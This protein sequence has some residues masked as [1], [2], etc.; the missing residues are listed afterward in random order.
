MKKI[1]VLLVATLFLSGCT[2]Q[3]NY[4]ME[5]KNDKS[6]DFSVI[7]AFDDELIDMM[8]SSEN[9]DTTGTTD[10]QGTTDTTGTVNNE[11]TDEE[12]WAFI[13]SLAEDSSELKDAGYTTE[14]YEKDGYKGIIATKTIDN[15]DDVTGENPNFYLANYD[16]VGDAVMFKKNGDTYSA[17]LILSAPDQAQINMNLNGTGIVSTFTVTLPNKPISHNAINVSEDGKTLTWN[18]TGN[19]SENIEF[20]FSFGNNM[21]LYI[22]LGIAGL[23][24]LLLIIFLVIKR[25]KNKKNK[26]GLTN[27]SNPNN[28][29]M[30][31][32]QTTSIGV[33]PNARNISQNLNINS[34]NANTVSAS[35]SLE[36]PSEVVPPMSTPV[37]NQNI[38]NVP[39]VTSQNINSVPPVINKNNTVEA[40]PLNFDS[41]QNNN[42]NNR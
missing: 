6:F 13:D 2:M 11:Y 23:I 31:A 3:G 19:G 36:T 14:R 9:S 35:K 25:R 15:I 38:N 20:E 24:V 12:R 33:Q 32:N 29:S 37:T 16:T 8:L 5:I 7:M 27:P 22:G 34:V 39:P 40:K 18:L 17:N 41:N 1:I 28:I 10:N 42:F 21:L 4:E 30:P 26:T